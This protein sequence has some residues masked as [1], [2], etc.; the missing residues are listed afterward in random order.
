MKTV[1]EIVDKVMV[2]VLSQTCVVAVLSV[3]FS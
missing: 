1:K 3:L 2:Q